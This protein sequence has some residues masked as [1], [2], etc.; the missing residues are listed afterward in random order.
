MFTF[1]AHHWLA[2][3]IFPRMY[4]SVGSWPHIKALSIPANETAR[5]GEELRQL[6][7]LHSLEL[8]INVSIFVYL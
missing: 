4:P 6:W 2:E 3:T 8:F 5:Y 1:F 7:A